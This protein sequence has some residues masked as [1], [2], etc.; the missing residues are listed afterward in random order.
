MK[1]NK[2]N[3]TLT[4]KMFK[5]A[6]NSWWVILFMLVC[7]I[8]Y[9]MGIKKRKLAI[10]E[11]KTKYNNLLVQ[12]NQATTRKEDLSLKLSSQSDPSWIEQVLMKELGVVPENKIKVHFKN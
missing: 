12:K 6:I 7:S 1:E 5:I 3:K 8:G 4:S 11:M 9:D 10:I 2:S